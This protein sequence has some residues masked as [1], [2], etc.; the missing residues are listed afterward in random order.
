MGAGIGILPGIGAVMCP[1]LV[2]WSELKRRTR[3]RST[4][5]GATLSSVPGVAGS[6]SIAQRGK[7]GQHLTKIDKRNAPMRDAK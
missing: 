6:I 5:A 2:G 1:F 7:S 3:V 4:G